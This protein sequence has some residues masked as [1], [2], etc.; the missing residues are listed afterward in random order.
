M[1]RF[2]SIYIH[3]AHFGYQ[4]GITLQGVPNRRY[5]LRLFVEDVERGANRRDNRTWMPVQ[6]QYVTYFPNTY[7]NWWI[8][9]C[10]DVSPTSQICTEVRMQIGYSF[11]A[12]YR[13]ANEVIDLHGLFNDY[14]G[15]NN[16]E[17]SV[18][19]QSISPTSLLISSE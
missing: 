17:F 19:G 10:R 3:T 12:K 8:C 18:L 4:T 14:W 15:S 11:W 1:G 13:E 9:V 5:T 2:T 16:H 6:P 7:T